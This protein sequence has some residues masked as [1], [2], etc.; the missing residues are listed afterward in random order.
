M[1]WHLSDLY[2]IRNQTDYYIKVADFATMRSLFRFRT[3]RTKLILLCSLLLLVPSL[4][5][6][7]IAYNQSKASLD[8]GGQV[9]L[10]ND[11]RYVIA[12][13]DA[14]HQQVKKG[15][16]PLEEAQETV[17]Q[18]ILGAKSADGKRPIN[19]KFDLGESGYMFIYDDKANVLAH[20][21]LEGQNFWDTKTPDGVMLGQEIVK[22]GKSGGGF[23]FY[24]WAL[25]DDPTTTAPKINYS[26]MEPNWGW[27]VNAGTYMSDFN[28]GANE[29]FYVIIVTL[30]IAV[31]AGGVIITVFS[32][33]LTRPLA[34][35][36]T[37]VEQIAEGDLT[38][39]IQVR[40]NDE[41]GQL[42]VAVNAMVDRLKLLIEGISQT[43]Q[44]VAAASQ[45]I[46]ASTEEIA[47][48]S[49][50]QANASQT[51]AELFKDL[52]AAIDNVAGKAEEAAELTSE[53]SQTAMEG[54]KAVTASID[55][56]NRVSEQMA[57]L[58]Q[59]SG[60]IGEIIEVIDD[61]AEQTNLLALNAAI[62]AARAGEVGRGFAVVAEEVR[63]LAER[64]SEATKQITQIIKGMQYN[65]KQSVES[66]ADG[67]EKSVVTGKAFDNII[68]KVQECMLKVAEIAA[69][70]EQ[71]SAQTGEVMQSVESIAATSEEAAAASEQT[72][73][74]S[75]SLAQSAEE[76]N[77]SLS[78][79][80]VSATN[81]SSKSGPA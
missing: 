72:A 18:Q 63:K 7:M 65:T 2:S 31:A 48:G 37:N 4:V 35:I 5:I 74:I 32:N 66:V 79:F 76:L 8:L 75:Y 42:G 36:A 64:S 28:K 33:S 54:G 40:T 16:L 15:Q 80:K 38:R 49:T 61:I 23:V 71:Q 73:A 60:R 81:V 59:D 39:Q 53:T 44:S 24:E 1:A 19:K 13:I 30:V 3:I 17:K 45:Q 77:A 68:G 10:K 69:A 46:S 29:I 6:G 78:L 12:M 47:S 21:L 25:P 56:M 51:I 41:V 11:V 9:Q 43:A 27:I 52:S 70:S 55:G 62:E 26:E 22:K 50:T 57:R 58:E 14:L 34:E 20:P 67:V